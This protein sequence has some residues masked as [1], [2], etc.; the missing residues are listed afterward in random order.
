[1]RLGFYQPDIPQ[2]LGAAVRLAACFGIGL[3]IIEPCGFPLTD[4][5]LRRTAMDYGDAVSLIRRDSWTDFRDSAR[6][7]GRRIV[8]FS[9]AADASL[10]MFRFAA[11]DVLLFGRESAGVPAEVH[12][13]A[14]ARVL[15]P[16]AP[17]QRSFNVV[18]SAAIG[19]W[20]ACRQTGAGPLA[21]G[22]D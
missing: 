11:S 15:I 22:S 4:R 1:M 7:A 9:T 10:E 13:E 18:A 3:E 16:L 2:N 6:S 21:R 5:A 17:E 12:R 8:L 20:E 19:L 14:D